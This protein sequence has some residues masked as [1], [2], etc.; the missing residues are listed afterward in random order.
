LIDKNSLFGGVSIGNME[1]CVKG[2]RSATYGGLGLCGCAM[3]CEGCQRQRGCCPD[4]LELLGAGSISPNLGKPVRFNPSPC[5][6]MSSSKRP[7]DPYR[8][9]RRREGFENLSNLSEAVLVAHWPW[10]GL[11]V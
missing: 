5:F 10:V 11:W 6:G 2:K 8:D 1:L 7:L 4:R 3:P 9:N